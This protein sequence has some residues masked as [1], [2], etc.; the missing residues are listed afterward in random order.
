M[1]TLSA[2]LTKS[3]IWH[4][5]LTQQNN[6]QFAAERE[7]LRNAFVAFRERASHLATEIRRDLPDLTVHDVSHTDALW[8]IA[9]LVVGPQHTFT[10]TE[11]FVLGGAFLLHDLA[12][13][14]AATDG[15]MQGLRRDPRWKDLIFAEYR[16]Q[17]DRDPNDA[18]QTSP[19]PKI[20][21]RALFSL[22]RQTH[23]E[24][25]EKLAFL[26]FPA[27][28]GGPLFLIEDTEIRQGLGRTIGKIAHS[29][30]WS[31]GEV[32]KSFDRQIG[33]P[34]WCPAAWTIDPRKIAC[35]LR[36]ADAAH[37][38]ARRAPTFLKS[39]N[40]L[41]DAS[42]QHWRFQE[43]LNKPYLQED[44]LVFTSGS[45]FQLSD[46]SSWWLC[47]ESLRDLDRELR[48][49]DSMFA[50]NS[51]PRLA[52]RRVAGVDIPE[53]LASYVQTEGWLPIN[54]VV[55]VSDLPHLIESIGGAE[56]YGKNPRV[57]VRELIQNACDAVRAR[58]KYE[59]REQDFGQIK[60]WLAKSQTNEW[61]L[62]YV[63]TG[64]AC[65]IECS[66]NFS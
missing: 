21:R 39:F 24:N 46:A 59:D 35:A 56:L 30:W 22:L 38:D 17:F 36:L 28:D 9:T 55:Q 4:T 53:R 13:S 11:A 20:E 26:S 63:T 66:P 2:T 14:I 34:H 33:A 54:A 32:E 61:W 62:E 16:A 50:D 6:D 10:P 64:W 12:M 43:K 31:I 49:V 51:S 47:L 5:T 8:E 45:S 42:E 29:H 25:A 44:A 48:S 19:I 58:R 15:G 65:P 1:G 40:K 37:L 41:S 23:A 18:E 60:V 27:T 7:R 57:A 52:A 3:Q